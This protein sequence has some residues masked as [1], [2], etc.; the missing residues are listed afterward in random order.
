E[1]LSQA[2]AAEVSTFGIKVTVVEP[3]GYSTDWG[4]ASAKLA[5][6]L[7]A[8]A[9]VHQAVQVARKARMGTP[10]DPVATRAAI[11][12]VVDAATP[13]LRIFFGD[14]P[15]AIATADYE[16]RLATWRAWEPVSIAAHGGEVARAAAAKQSDPA[17]GDPYDE[18]DKHTFAD[19]PD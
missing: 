14:G 9:E 13:P 11:L 8:Y 5:T 16:S 2:L 19:D 10:G 18:A 17:A 12:A 1:G 4:G 3:T 15:L 7:P 6:P